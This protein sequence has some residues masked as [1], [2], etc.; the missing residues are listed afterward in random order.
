MD[1]EYGTEADLREFIVTAHKLGLRVLLDLVYF[2]CAPTCVL[3]ERDGFIQ[4]DA[5][6]KAITGGW[7]S[8][9]L[10]FQNPRLREYLWAD[11]EHWVKDYP[12]E[13]RQRDPSRDRALRGAAEEKGR[14]GRLIVNV[15]M[16]RHLL[17]GPG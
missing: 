1:P 3:M 15:A 8:P 9:R 11:R 7:N 16:A 4:R 10:N 13:V 2:H 17:G 12:G 5:S 6:G 14:T